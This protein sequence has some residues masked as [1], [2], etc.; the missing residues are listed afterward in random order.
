MTEFAARGY[1]HLG[2]SEGASMTAVEIRSGKVDIGRVI[3]RTFEVLGRNAALYFGMT[4]L[5]AAVPG[6]IAS[7]LTVARASQG[8][9]IFASPL[10]WLQLF[11]VV[12]FSSFVAATTYDLA[13]ADLR[14]QPRTLP[15]A[16]SAGLKLFLPLFVVNLLFYLA[17]GLGAAIFLAPGL[18]A[19]TAWCVAGPALIDER[20][21]I[22]QSFGRSDQL[23][24]NNRWRILGLM[25]L[26]LLVAFV[27]QAVLGAI[28][29]A[30]S[31]GAG[32]RATLLSTPR[33][34]GS[35][36]LNT[37]TTAVSL[38]G[39]AVLYAELRNLKQGVGAESLSE[40]FD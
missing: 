24:R 25:L 34:I 19:L 27:L 32:A 14:G 1:L 17:G 22:F 15:Q 26:F 33:L 9:Q 8:V 18:L 11:V 38:V 40:V 36:V 7:L 2:L 5:F 29:L 30:T 4:F 16:M 39:V 21:G 23:T 37:L 12:F 10:Y 31:V 13:L 35:M 20:T 28:G 6:A 3:R